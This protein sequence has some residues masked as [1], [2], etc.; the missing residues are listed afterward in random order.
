M[1]D[2]I[3]IIHSK[4][5]MRELLKREVLY[6]SY[7]VY[8]FREETKNKFLEIKEKNFFENIE[9]LELFT[10]QQLTD[11][12]NRLLKYEYQLIDTQDSNFMYEHQQYGEALLTK[13]GLYFSTSFDNSFE[14]SMTASEFTDTKEFRKYDP[15]L[16]KWE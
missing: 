9:N 10:N 11:I 4:I 1:V 13:K 15:Q 8:I 2:I 3:T 14:V 12:K 7:D 5:H 6:M 16:G